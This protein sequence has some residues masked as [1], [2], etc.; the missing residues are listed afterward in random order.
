MAEG[1][2]LKKGSGS[3]ERKDQVFGSESVMDSCED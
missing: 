2:G 3:F 1:D